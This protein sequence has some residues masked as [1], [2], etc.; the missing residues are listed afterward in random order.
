MEA[1]ETLRE[2]R[3]ARE[4]A[5]AQTTQERAARLQERAAADAQ[6][7]E[8]RAQLDRQRNQ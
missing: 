3:A 7:A 5:E 6:I 2:E 4:A 8:L 1:N